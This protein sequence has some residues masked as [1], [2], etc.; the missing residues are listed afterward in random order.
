MSS[1]GL[2]NLRNLERQQK[3]ML[4]FDNYFLR[5]LMTM[6]QNGE[7]HPLY[8]AE[9]HTGGDPRVPK[10]IAVYGVSKERQPDGTV[11]YDKKYTERLIDPS[12]YTGKTMLSNLVKQATAKQYKPVM[13]RQ[14]DLPLFV[15]TIEDGVDTIT[16]KK[17]T[18]FWEQSQGRIDPDTG[19]YEPGPRTGVFITLDS[20]T[21][22]DA[23]YRFKDIK[24]TLDGWDNN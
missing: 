20:F 18:G 9:Y 7:K 23:Q 15:T 11:T 19:N 24:E 13:K 14:Y 4:Q 1:N 17:G 8:I 5:G 3:N 21:W 12:P 6:T 2:S 16:G 22:Q 10:T